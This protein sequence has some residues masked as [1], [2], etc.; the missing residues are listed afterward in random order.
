MMP[1]TWVPWPNSSF[2]GSPLPL[3]T[4]KSWCDSAESIFSVPCVAKCGWCSSMPESSTAQTMSWP[5]AENDVRA[6]SAFTVD[7]L[8]LISALIWKSGQIR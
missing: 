1:A 3:K 4:V 7:R 5:W 2:N 8:R 6:A